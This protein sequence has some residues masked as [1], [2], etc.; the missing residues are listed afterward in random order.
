MLWRTC[1]T[2]PALRAS[3]TPPL[4]IRNDTVGA[5]GRARPCARFG[6]HRTTRT[7]DVRV[8][9]S[10]SQ[11]SELICAPIAS[12][13]LKRGSKTGGG[14]GPLWKGVAGSAGVWCLGTEVCEICG[15]DISRASGAYAHCRGRLMTA[16]ARS[17]GL[18][19]RTIGR[20]LVV[21]FPRLMPPV[22]R[23]H[24]SHEN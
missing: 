7:G 10:I 20:L 9:L 5:G 18:L 12:F 22:S 13:R 4:F 21:Q 1:R 3:R 24:P 6:G 17:R 14:G 11:L 2:H 16:P 19:K 8:H 15:T 23:P